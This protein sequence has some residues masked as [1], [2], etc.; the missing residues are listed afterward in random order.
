MRTVGALR[1]GNSLRQPFDP[2]GLSE[3]GH[4]LCVAG[5]RRVCLFEEQVNAGSGLRQ[6]A[7]R[8]GSFPSS[9]PRLRILRG[10]EV[11]PGWTA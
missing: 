3:G 4:W 6:G 2:L 10:P 7:A 11:A 1:I 8:S 5:F 9:A